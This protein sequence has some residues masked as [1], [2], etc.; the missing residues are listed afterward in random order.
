MNIRRMLSIIFFFL[1]VIVVLALAPSINTAN[2]TV[3]ATWA[4]AS[5]N[6]SMIGMGAVVPFGAPLIILSI[7]VSFGLL[8]FG[9]KEGASV[10]DIMEAIGITIAMII[11]LNFFDSAVGYVNTL[12]VDATGIAKVIYGIIPLAVY[13]GIVASAGSYGIVKY[14]KGKKGKKG[15]EKA[16]ALANY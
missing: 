16:A 8:A 1:T 12:L 6:A 15:K 10:R 2:S 9:M 7:M 13:I 5:E 11:A 4:L 14:V 3:L